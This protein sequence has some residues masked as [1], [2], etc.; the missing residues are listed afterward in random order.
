MINLM[1]KKQEEANNANKQTKHKKGV[2]ISENCC[3]IIFF[4]YFFLYSVGNALFFF[5]SIWHTY[6]RNLTI[7]I[8]YFR[9]SKKQG[10]LIALTTLTVL[11]AVAVA[12]MITLYCFQHKHYHGIP[13]SAANAELY[14]H[15]AVAA[16][17]VRCSEI[18]MSKLD[19]ISTP[20]NTSQKTTVD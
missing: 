20:L 15:G 14:E 7:F 5:T 17:S 16:D 1:V 6:W 3:R 4:P 10:I 2:V 8:T 9:L 18:G 13:K 12:V 19:F 11:S